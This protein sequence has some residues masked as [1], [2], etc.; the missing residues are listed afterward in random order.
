MYNRTLRKVD[1]PRSKQ[2]A[3][4]LYMDGKSATVRPH[5]FW[6][7]NADTPIS[8]CPSFQRDIRHLALSSSLGEIWTYQNINDQK[9]PFMVHCMAATPSAD[10]GMI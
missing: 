1:S 2:A 9:S 8:P 10:K 3:G 6:P 7:I 4:I 5:V